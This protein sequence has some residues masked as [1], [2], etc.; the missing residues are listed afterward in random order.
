MSRPRSSRWLPFPAKTDWFMRR[1]GDA[2]PDIDIDLASLARPDAVTRVLAAVTRT[3]AGPEPEEA[4]I[5]ALPVGVRTAALL[6]TALGE[7]G[8]L[9]RVVR[10]RACLERSEIEL[11]LSE[12]PPPP[13]DPLQLEVDGEPWMLRLPSGADQRAWQL[14][15]VEPLAVAQSLLLTPRELRPDLLPRLAD[16]MHE[17]DPLT[18]FHVATQCVNCEAGILAPLDLE[19]IALGVLAGAQRRVLDDVHRLAR[20]YHWSEAQ[21]LALPAWR[22]AAYLERVDGRRA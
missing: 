1:F 4:H 6:R 11:P 7:A 20:A 19:H 3:S 15:G 13:C 22:C 16:A 21:I 18:D 14:A 5:W 10:C 12:L 2:S 17:H 9:Q 8:T